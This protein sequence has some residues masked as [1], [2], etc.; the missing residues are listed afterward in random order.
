MEVGIEHIGIKMSANILKKCSTI[1]KLAQYLSD[2]N[3]QSSSQIIIEDIIPFNEV[4]YKEC[5]YNS[6]FPVITYFKGD[7]GYFFANDII[8]YKYDD[9]SQKAIKFEVE[10]LSVQ[11]ENSVLDA[12]GVGFQARE[13]VDDVVKEVKKSI[14]NGKPVIVWVDCFY[15]SIRMDTYKKQHLHTH[16]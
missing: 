2:S 8:L 11:D 13:Q 4:F 15:E 6:L 1:R 16:Y 7:I 9:N 10:Y 14:I 12:C 5:F 3:H